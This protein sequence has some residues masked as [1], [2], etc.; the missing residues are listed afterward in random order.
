MFLWRLP[1]SSGHKWAL[2]RLW[3][4]HTFCRGNSRL[5][6]T[7]TNSVR[8][9]GLS[10]RP[11]SA[12]TAFLAA[13]ALLALYEPVGLVRWLRGAC[14]SLSAKRRVIA[15]APRASMDARPFYRTHGSTLYID[16]FS[17]R[18]L[19]EVLTQ[20]RALSSMGAFNKRGTARCFTL[21]LTASAEFRCGF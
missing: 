16:H 3:E 10:T 9:S 2:H 18:A 1:L 5:H 6:N 21:R 7:L 14:F 20:W 13:A 15:K 11:P 12:A 4:L 17:A 19:V 8:T